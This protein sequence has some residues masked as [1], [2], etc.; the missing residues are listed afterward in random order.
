MHTASTST[1]RRSRSRAAGHLLSTFPPSSSPPTRRRATDY[2]LHLHPL[3]SALDKPL[4][5]RLRNPPRLRLPR[6]GTLP[7]SLSRFQPPCP[8][9]QKQPFCNS[10]TPFP[11][12][13]TRTT[14]LRVT[15]RNNS[16][17]TSLEKRQKDSWSSSRSLLG[18][19]FLPLSR[20]IRRR[21]IDSS[22]QNG[23]S[24]SRQPR[25][26]S[27]S[28]PILGLPDSDFARKAHT[29]SCKHSVV[30][31][32]PRNACWCASFLFPSTAGD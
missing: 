1:L 3:Q 2:P 4:P 18:C 25:R 21:L 17:P 14:R 26:A 28:P 23:P 12:V 13:P 7:L 11:P 20:S 9:M 24:R 8:P 19:T 32:S 6:A 29:T 10:S 16:S 27:R 31:G 30:V 5:N 15:C 22:L